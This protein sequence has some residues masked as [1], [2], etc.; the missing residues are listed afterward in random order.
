LARHRR[1][2]DR[3]VRLHANLRQDSLTRMSDEELDAEAERLA[4]ILGLQLSD[5][6][7]PLVIEEL[8]RQVS[9]DF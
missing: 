8:Q 7:N 4:A 9:E 2:L 3:L 5:L 1:R 6:G